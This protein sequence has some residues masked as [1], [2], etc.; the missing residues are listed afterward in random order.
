MIKAAN[1]REEIKKIFQVDLPYRHIYHYTTSDVAIK[2][3]ESK[4]SSEFCCTHY[5]F[6]NDD[7]EFAK[8]IDIV[9]EW[10]KYKLSKIHSCI[11]KSDIEERI[12]L[13]LKP[14]IRRSIEGGFTPWIL[15]FSKDM[16]SVSQW[17]SY[18][19]HSRGGIA[20]GVNFDKLIESIIPLRSID[21]IELRDIWLV[22]PCVYIEMDSKGK[23]RKFE[24]GVL[25][26]LFERYGGMRIFE[27]KDA[28][29]RFAKIAILFAALIK[30]S[31]F[32]MEHEWRVVHLT[33]ESFCLDQVEFIGGK[34]RIRLPHKRA[35]EIVGKLVVSHHGNRERL[36]LIADILAEKYHFYVKESKTSYTGA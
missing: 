8:G 10:L 23:D 30:R 27:T 2:I 1:Y 28:V 20:I 5:R 22:A 21:W 32:R 19:D 3:L 36:K 7:E 26:R 4:I 18:T 12:S 13:I 6:L 33:D 11:S 17:A 24:Y 29:L 35:N 15:S 9:L 16:D 14:K 31:D 25:D 34:P